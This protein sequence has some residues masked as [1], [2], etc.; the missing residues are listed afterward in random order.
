MKNFKILFCLLIFTTS[1]RSQSFYKKALVI[2]AT[3]GIDIYDTKVSYHLD[4]NS[5]VD[6]TIKGTGKAGCKSFA[7]GA[8]YGLGKKVGAGLRFKSNTYYVS[9]DE[10]TGITPKVTSFDYMAFLNYHLV[11]KKHFDLLAGMS[12]GGT[13][14]NYITNDSQGNTLTGNGL[15][16]DL[17]VTPRIYFGRFG[18]EAGIYMP[19][20]NYTSMTSN[21]TDFNNYVLAKWKGTG[22]GL[23]FGI[24]YRFGKNPDSK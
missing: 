17:H 19:F 1:I 3:T 20:V 10:T 14:L 13:H 6:T 24:Q 16:F 21:N 23:N 18:I 12:I 22:Y 7:F 9:K 5:N 8:E 11:N 4:N 2:D 15:W